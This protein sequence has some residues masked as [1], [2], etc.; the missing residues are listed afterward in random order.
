[1]NIFALAKTL[2]Y[3]LLPKNTSITVNDEINK[4][5]K[6]LVPYRTT[7]S[8]TK[9]LKPFTI[10][11]YIIVSKEVDFDKSY[12]DPIIN[13]CV[14]VFSSFYLRTF[15]ILTELDNFDANIAFRLLQTS[16]VRENFTICTENLIN[17]ISDYFN[18]IGVGTEDSSDNK[19]GNRITEHHAATFSKEL[20]ITLKNN[21][22]EVK[23]PIV[24][25]P[26][27]Q[28][29][30][31]EDIIDSFDHTNVKST[32]T[33]RKLAYK[34]GSI[35]WWNYITGNDLAKKYKEKRIKD[36]E[37]SNI[38]DQYN[39][40]IN[41]N[42]IK[43]INA[44]KGFSANYNMLLLTVDELERLSNEYMFNIMGN[45]KERQKWM[46]ASKMMLVFAL[47]VDI[48]S[49]MIFIS[50][51]SEPYGIS[52]KAIEKNKKEP[53]FNTAISAIMAGRPPVF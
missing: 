11:P 12:R 9:F 23:V 4:I 5:D 26:T 31:I 27:I 38:L 3:L 53:D 7:G 21:N 15:K 33:A 37:K 10:E 40:L 41:T 25:R 51:Y 20:E 29:A 8:L 18:N 2:S 14:N 36:Y 45:D 46:D 17:E 22:N 1:M 28:V 35:S 16:T 39:K 32:R 49:G 30:P 19:G 43:L 48:E 34:A 6:N 50:D 44:G 47:D 24:I 52:L 42:N 13:Y